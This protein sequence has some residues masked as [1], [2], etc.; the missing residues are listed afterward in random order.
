MGSTLGKWAASV[1]LGMVLVAC[2]ASLM[3]VW[4]IKLAAEMDYKASFVS[5]DQES[6]F[7]LYSDINNKIEFSHIGM[8]G[9][10]LQTRQTN[11]SINYLNTYHFASFQNN[12]AVFFTRNKSDILFYNPNNNEL[13]EGL[14][15]TP[16]AQNQTYVFSNSYV[17]KQGKLILGARKFTYASNELSELI[18]NTTVL[19]VINDQGDVEH[20]WEHP[21]VFSFRMYSTN[22]GF[23]IEGFYTSAYTEQA[24]AYSV[25]MQFDS[26]AQM[27]NLF[28][29][30]TSTRILDIVNDQIFTNTQSEGKGE[31]SVYS[32][33]GEIQHQYFLEQS[34][35]PR[36][37]LKTPIAFDDDGFYVIQTLND[38]SSPVSFINGFE[39]CRYD[40]QFQQQ[41]CRSHRE[42]GG[43]DVDIESVSILPDGSIGFS[44]LMRTVRIHGGEFQ[45]IPLDDFVGGIL[46]ALGREESEVQHWVFSSEGEVLMHIYEPSYYHEGIASFNTSFGTIDIYDEFVQPGVCK[47]HITHFI[48]TQEIVAITPYCS[49]LEDDRNV[50]IKRWNQ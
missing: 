44:T 39:A 32:L 46:L 9:N 24:G 42:S 19:L 48:N 6:F 16:L 41:W 34:L 29:F 21:N 17:T 26:Q 36:Y 37:S 14:R 30:T 50:Q 7:L 35:Q 4:E 27:S 28:E 49:T 25:I 12:K 15:T 18:D 38:N 20:E 43:Y 1:V 31:L 8:D 11:L 40:F 5:S 3:P 2:G 22:D 13:Q 47:S 10:V 23:V 45:V 33:A